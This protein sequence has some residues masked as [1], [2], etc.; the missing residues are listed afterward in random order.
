VSSFYEI[1]AVV[2]AGLVLLG[3][4]F[5]GGLQFLQ[6]VVLVAERLEKEKK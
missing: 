5:F 1:A 4:G 2:A 3:I 6:F